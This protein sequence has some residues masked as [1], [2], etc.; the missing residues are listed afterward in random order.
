MI[1]IFQRTDK[2]NYRS[3]VYTFFDYYFEKTTTYRHTNAEF[4]LITEV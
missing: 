3:H 2:F 1:L 4:N